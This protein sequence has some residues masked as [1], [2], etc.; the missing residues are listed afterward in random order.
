MSILTTWS[1]G[2]SR[3]PRTPPLVREAGLSLSVENLIACASAV[4]RTTSSPLRATLAL[5]QMAR[6]R[7][8]LYGR[9]YVVPEDVKAVGHDVLRHRIL[10]TYE[11]EARQLDSDDIVTSLFENVEVP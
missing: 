5:T 2:A 4:I 7:A 9:T 10:V 11:A 3:M 6:A 1:S 8:L